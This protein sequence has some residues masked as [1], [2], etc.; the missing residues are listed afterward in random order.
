MVIR[1]GWGPGGWL[2]GDESETWEITRFFR[3]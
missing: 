2:V 1:G 3:G